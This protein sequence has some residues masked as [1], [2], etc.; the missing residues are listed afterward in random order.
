MYRLG[1]QKRR[2]E[3]ENGMGNGAKIGSLSISILLVDFRSGCSFPSGL[4]ARKQMGS[5]FSR[6]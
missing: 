2:K 3:A 5:A 1:I 6:R 4:L